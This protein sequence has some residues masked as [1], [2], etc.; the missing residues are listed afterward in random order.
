[1]FRQSKGKEHQESRAGAV[2]LGARTTETFDLGDWTQL[3]QDIDPMSRR[4]APEIRG[5][6]ASA[7]T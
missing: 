5:T 2:A 4:E 3:P 6:G 7:A 1:M